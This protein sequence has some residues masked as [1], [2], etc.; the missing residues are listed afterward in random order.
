MPSLDPEQILDRIGRRVAELRAEAGLTQ[1]RLAEALAVSVQYLQRVEGG[2]EN[3]TVRSLVRIATAL[4]V[5]FTA[6]FKTPRLKARK[7]G[8]PKRRS[9]ARR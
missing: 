9:A 5:A 3:L 1:D 6:L 7:P 4:G 8:R 2:R